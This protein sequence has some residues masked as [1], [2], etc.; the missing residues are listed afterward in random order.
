MSGTDQ[1][2][3]QGLLDVWRPVIASGVTIVAVRD[4]PTP[5]LARKDL[6]DCISRVDVSQINDLCSLDRRKAL[7]S[8]FDAYKAAADQTPGAAFIDMSRFFCGPTTCPVVI[9]GVD[10]Y[11]DSNHV[12]VTF[13]KS[14]APYYAKALKDLGLLGATTG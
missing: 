7:D 4:N 13:Q 14:L 2:Q 6:Q 12:T 9:G 5:M 3:V 1:E 11:R 10:V 8:R